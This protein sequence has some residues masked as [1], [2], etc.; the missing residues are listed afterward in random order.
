ML[1]WDHYGFDKGN[2]DT[3]RYT[4]IFASG[5][6]SE[7]HSALRCTKR[8]H[9]FFILGWDRYGFDKKRSMTR[10]AELV[11]LHPVGSAGHI[12]HS[13]AS[14]ARNIGTPFFMLGCDRYGFP[15][16]RPGTHFTKLVFSHPVGYAGHVVHSGASGSRNV[17][18]LFFMLG[19]D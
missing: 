11:F 15:K 4:F 14:E 7:S 2:R 8:R 5:G 9:T 13:S 19:W 12:V 16:N 10:C 6:I 1:R 17:D 18:V 3:L